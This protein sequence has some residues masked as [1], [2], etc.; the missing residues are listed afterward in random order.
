MNGEHAGRARDHV[1]AQSGAMAGEDYV[2]AVDGAISAL[3]KMIDDVA[4]QYGN[5]SI[6]S[7]KGFLAEAFHV[8]TF[9]VDAARRGLHEVVAERVGDN[10]PVD[11][12]VHVGADHTDYQIKYYRNPGET[13]KALSDPQ[14][15][16]MGKVGPADQVDSIRDEAL[17]RADRIEANRPEQAA[18]LRDT[19]D[20][21]GG[22]L[23]GGGAR[24][25]SLDHDEALRLA[26]DGQRGNVNLRDHGISLDQVIE[27]LD[28]A[29]EAAKAG[30]SA[31]AI[32]AAMAAAPHVIATLRSAY[33]G[34]RERA[35]ASLKAAANEGV[36]GGGAGFLRGAVASGVQV[37]CRTGLLG[38]AA[39]SV[40][41]GAVGA[42]TAMVLRAMVDAYRL[43][44]GEI[45]AGQF[46]DRTAGGCAAG[47]AGMYGAV[48]GQ[49]LI[50]IP[51][52]GALV[53][54]LVGSLIGSA[55]Y[56]GLKSGL[57][58]AENREAWEAQVTLLSQIAALGEAMQVTADGAVRL[59]VAQDVLLR[60]FEGSVRAWQ[61]QSVRLKAKIAQNDE[62][63]RDFDERHRDITS[64]LAAL[65]ARLANG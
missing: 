3:S 62:K 25:H 32:S 57:R 31:V 65:Q 22:H 46:A 17:A 52:V 28:V 16:G 29:R 26:R 58:R 50:P 64:R 49:A 34:D 2:D 20:H 60:T 36:H 10:G 59:V 14:Y 63:L 54:S 8:G 13:A 47:T 44:R 19:A 6:H 55:G 21:A 18:Q 15:G 53:G 27:P 4:T 30:A 35:I 41:P 56:D 61:T 48:A 37:V 24:S 43:S 38:E 23:E 51:I 7:A 33:E 42:M 39:R 1:A 11:A 9:N 45:S 5:N 40:S 12:R